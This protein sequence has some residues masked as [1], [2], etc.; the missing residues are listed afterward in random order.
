M[1]SNPLALFLSRSIASP[2]AITLGLGLGSI[3]FFFWGNLAGQPT[4]AI[5]IPVNPEVRRKLGIDTSKAVEIWKW[6]YIR[7]AAYFGVSGVA[8]SLAVLAAA[9]QIPKSVHTDGLK[10]YLLLLSGLLLSN[11][12]YTV[13]IMLPTNNRLKAIGD[14]IARERTASGTSA[15]PLTETQANEAEALFKKWRRMHLV[16][17]TLGGIGWLGTLAA[18]V[19]SV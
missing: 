19:T 18:Y 7:G 9:F 13:A 5:V 12:I 1:S 17:V 3:S 16:R 15:A 10:S 14:K 4:G 2:Y 11:G 6:A 8:S